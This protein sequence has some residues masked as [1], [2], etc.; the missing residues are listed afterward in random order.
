MRS[1]SSHPGV[2]ESYQCFQI[3][4]CGVLVR[5]KL[6]LKILECWLLELVRCYLIIEYFY[7]QVQLQSLLHKF[8]LI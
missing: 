7:P 6:I 8:A 1:G 3:G 5:D 2:K 4:H